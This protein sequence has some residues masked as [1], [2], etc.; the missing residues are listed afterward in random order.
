MTELEWPTSENKWEKAGWWHLAHSSRLARM[1]RVDRPQAGQRLGDTWSIVAAPP[2]TIKA[3]TASTMPSE[4]D[5]SVWSFADGG[6][7][8]R[9]FLVLLLLRSLLQRIER[10]RNALGP[11]D[12]RE[13]LR[14]IV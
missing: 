14:S 7:D 10:A 13:V 5:I 4:S 6:T 1:S 2:R 9:L 12:D 3:T 8:N 11:L